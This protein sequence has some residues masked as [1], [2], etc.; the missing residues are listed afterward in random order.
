MTA[1]AA[2]TTGQVSLRAA[3]T[4]RRIEDRA[5]LEAMLAP[6]RPYAAYAMAYLD[7]RLFQL[8]AFY[9]ASL[10]E[11]RALLMQ[12]RGGLGLSSFAFGDPLLLGALLR[13]HPGPR[14]SFF[15]CEVEHVDTLLKSHDLWHPQNML[16][17]A[18]SP[19]TYLPATS[20]AEVRR[21]IP[22]DAADLNHLYAIEDDGLRL[23]GRQVENG[24]YYGAYSRNRL[25]A[26]AGT[27]I[28]SAHQGIAVLGN[29]YTHPDFRNHG[30][31]TAVTAAVATKL[32]QTCDLVVLNV[33]PA[34]R[35]AR[36]LY[37]KLG[38]YETGR[39]AEAMATR[40]DPFSPLPLLRRA[41]ARRRS[42]Q[43]ELEVIDL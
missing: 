1:H 10:G 27:H 15:T 38:F 14:Q 9:E 36:H 2:K 20:Q 30:L 42:G 29:V 31:A 24:V 19:H 34:N 41:L 25:V 18:V 23:S 3:V 32:L 6:A 35:T 12:A 33:D 17:M 43:P 40:R 39:L 16:R 13:L 8:A 21:L 26:T 28:H 5:V 22:A 4:V 37:E 11:R 7:P